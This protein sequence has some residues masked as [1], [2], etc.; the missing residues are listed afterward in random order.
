MFIKKVNR[1]FLLIEILIG[2]VVG[3]VILAGVISI[4]SGLTKANKDSLQAARLDHE[5]RSAMRLMVDDIRRAGFYGTADTM[6]YTG[7][8]SNPYMAAAT[9]LQVPTASCILLCY[10][11]NADGIMPALNTA[12]GDE[13]YGFRLVNNTLQTRA[14]TDSM[15][16]CTQGAWENLTNPNVVEMTNLAFTLNNTVMPVSG[17]STA[18]MTIRNVTITMSARL[19]NDTAVS[20]TLTEFVRVRNDKFTP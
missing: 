16:S 8:N 17:S 6:M 10:D 12:G 7:A 3:I 19:K 2:L 20:R 14:T 11:K 1:G 18:T 13:H 4:F 9:D 15:Y 5:I